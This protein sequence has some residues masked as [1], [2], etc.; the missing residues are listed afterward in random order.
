M[1]AMTFTILVTMVCT[2]TLA[3]FALPPYESTLQA[4]V[5][6]DNIVHVTDANKFWCVSGDLTA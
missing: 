3:V 4:R 2:A 5:A 6:V 1:N